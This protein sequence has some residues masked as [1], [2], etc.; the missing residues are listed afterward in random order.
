MFQGKSIRLQSLTADVVELCFDR[1]GDA[2]NKFDAA[3]VEEL[4]LAT[5][6]LR[7]QPNLRG[8][9]VS[10]A[11]NVFI[12]GADIFE[13]ITLFRQPEADIRAKLATQNAVFTQFEDLPVPIVTAINGFAL[14][15]GLELGLAS[16]YRVIAATAQVGL[17]EVTLGL[18]PGFGGTV[19]LPRLAG[20]A[21][22]ID[23]IISGK[24]RDAR[25]AL[26]CGVV[27]EVAA[28]EK[29]REAALAQLQQAITSG[30]WRARRE[31]RIG[32]FDLAGES[33]AQA[34]LQLV[35][36][37]TR[38]PAALAALELME[39][40]VHCNRDEALKREHAAFACI[41]RTQAAASLVQ[42]FINEQ[43]IKSKAKSYAKLARKIERVAV[44]GAGIM[45]GGIAYT[46]AASG[47]PVLMKDIAPK[48]LEHGMTE[49]KQ[50]LDKQVQAGRMSAD[51]ASAVL[52]A[53]QP[54]LDF[55]NFVGADVVIEAVVEN[56]GVKKTV[57]MEVEQRVRAD[58]IIASN[59]SSLSIATMAQVLLRPENFVGM[60]FFNPVPVMPLV[61]VIRGPQ[62]SAVTAATVAGYAAS[63]AKTPVVVKDCP[64]FLVN[65]ILTAYMVGYFRT[66]HDGADYQAVDRTMEGFGWPMGPA[67]L[68]DVVGMDTMLHVMN[69][70]TG[71]YP[72]RMQLDFE[73]T[74][75]R[76]VEERRLGQKTGQGYYRYE[77]DS[78][79]KLAKL[80]D[81]RTAEL[82]E[83]LQPQGPREFSEQEIIERLM[84]PMVIEAA[85]CLEEGVA[86]SAAEI[87]MALVLGL[88][89][90]RHVGGALKYADWMGLRQVIRR[91][92][93]NA[94]LGPLY[95]PTERMREM[96][97]RA[98]RFL[99]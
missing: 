81:L 68:Q 63:M 91:C 64:G 31:R 86:E 1:A 69:V 83:L 28:P 94:A 38:Q 35:K 36:Q 7:T 46:S 29:L 37:A 72:A 77:K 57:L 25:T 41:A 66:L 97:R 47:V 80:V 92:D 65:R 59:T 39:S 60:H 61:E 51:K 23:W 52:A 75:H 82:I 14:G 5:A 42:L 13:F 62:T 24:P 98:E 15:G 71:G 2:I 79:G 89:F 9:L 17:P 88:G 96:A 70:I 30:K 49:A 76:M 93:A 44:L 87:D 8:V 34:K 3:T 10:S 48:A 54:Q 12:V 18:F 85:I 50:L 73:T 40:C 99:G 84:L 11:K 19:R 43:L 45:G 53:I 67:Y 74:L 95:A 90:P 58:A 27:D 4:K 20:A 16:D 56:L 33:F 78:K 55:Q 21:V 22:A 32:G 6:D 26:A